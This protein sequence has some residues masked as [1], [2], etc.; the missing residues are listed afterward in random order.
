MAVADTAVADM[1]AADISVSGGLSGEAVLL[2]SMVPNFSLF[3]SLH[4]SEMEEHS[5]PICPHS[6]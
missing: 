6:A 4:N 3:L 5:L 1:A 2:V